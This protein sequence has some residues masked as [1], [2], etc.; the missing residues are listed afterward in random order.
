MKRI[1]GIILIIAGVALAVV[2][3]NRHEKDR[4]IIDLGK[5]EL[6]NENKAPSES[7]TLYYVLAAVCVI[8]GG[9]LVAGKK[10]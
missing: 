9:V 3:Y 1:I 6:K 8:G 2:A 10:A 5:I 7:T 4:T